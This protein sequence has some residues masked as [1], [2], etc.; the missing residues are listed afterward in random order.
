[1]QYI[2]YAWFRLQHEH[3]NL[4][5]KCNR[6]PSQSCSDQSFR[7]ERAFDFSEQNSLLWEWPDQVE[8]INKMKPDFDWH[9]FC[10]SLS[11]AFVSNYSFAS[12]ITSKKNHFQFCEANLVDS[13][14]TVVWSDIHLD[15]WNLNLNFQFC[16]CI[17]LAKFS[18]KPAEND[19]LKIIYWISHLIH[20]VARF[21]WTN[22]IM[23]IANNK[24]ENQKPRE[25]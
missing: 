19:M 24:R 2:K 18:A 7:M 12:F 23:Q 8:L 15:K 13:F 25:P 21:N 11:S 20:F 10:L 1:M 6:L 22:A 16:I 14:N 4:S 3:W 5:H 17:I 9:S